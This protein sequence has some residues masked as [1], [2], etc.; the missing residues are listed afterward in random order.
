MAWGLCNIYYQLIPDY[1]FFFGLFWLSFYPIIMA[2][3]SWHWGLHREMS[4]PRMM[5]RVNSLKTYYH[6]NL[7]IGL[8]FLIWFG[9]AWK[10]EGSDYISETL[11]GLDK[12]KIAEQLWAAA[13]SPIP[14]FATYFYTCCAVT[15]AF[16][17][18]ISQEHNEAW[19]MHHGLK[20]ANAE[21]IADTDGGARAT[22]AQDINAGTHGGV[23]EKQMEAR[24]KRRLKLRRAAEAGCKGADCNFAVEEAVIQDWLTLINDVNLPTVA[25]KSRAKK[26][27]FNKRSTSPR[28]PSANPPE[29]TLWGEPAQTEIGERIRALQG[30]TGAP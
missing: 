11:A 20:H 14:L 3:F 13:P 22:I 1:R 2:A 10:P 28:V 23:V 7:C 26:V 12:Q 19:L 8:G 16:I 5:A 15:D 27:D 18:C 29:H 17:V 4:I 9:V 6:M 21:K 24:Q 25:E 30:G